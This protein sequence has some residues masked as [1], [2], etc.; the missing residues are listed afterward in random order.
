MYLRTYNNWFPY[1]H[2]QIRPSNNRYQ[3]LIRWCLDPQESFS[4]SFSLFIESIRKVGSC[5]RERSV[6]QAHLDWC[7]LPSKPRE[8]TNARRSASF[9]TLK[10]RTQCKMRLGVG[11]PSCL[12]M[13]LRYWIEIF[14]AN[15][16]HVAHL[17]HYHSHCHLL[18]RSNTLDLSPHLLAPDDR[19]DDCPQPITSPLS[20]MPPL[21]LRLSST[22][23]FATIL[24]ALSFLSLAI[25]DPLL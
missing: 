11:C 12:R 4:C 16:G 10:A 6:P 9:A 25:H 21:V 1:A 8:A 7:F 23:H 18:H 17:Y 2:F 20:L 22:T 24:A 3:N 14:V 19:R 5:L 13:D 15:L